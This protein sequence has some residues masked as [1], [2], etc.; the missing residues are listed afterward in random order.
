LTTRTNTC[1][2]I[3]NTD[4]Q[5][6]AVEH[7]DVHREDSAG[8]LAGPG[9]ELSAEQLQKRAHYLITRAIITGELVCPDRCS[10]CGYEQKRRN[11]SDYRAIHAHHDDY[12][13]PFDISWLCRRCHAKRHAELGWGGRRLP[14][15]SEANQDAA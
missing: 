6:M 10:V 9:T 14:K 1:F 7:Q 5:G 8:T 15:F 3:V 12:S 4:V 11:R 13:K 2:P